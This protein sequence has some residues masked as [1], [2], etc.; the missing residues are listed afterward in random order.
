MTL[1]QPLSLSLLSALALSGFGN[2]FDCS[3]PH[4]SLPK[5]S[6]GLPS[7]GEPKKKGTTLVTEENVEGKFVIKG[8]FFRN[9][10]SGKQCKDT[11]K[12]KR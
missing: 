6:A 8:T 3:L 11:I 5:K 1:C 2:A 9:F 7:G 10:V 4:T 12:G